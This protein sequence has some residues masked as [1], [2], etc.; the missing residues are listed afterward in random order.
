MLVLRE[1]LEPP[2]P[3]YKG[4]ASTPMLAK[5]QTFFSFHVARCL[6]VGGAGFEPAR[7]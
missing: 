7:A 3:L 4:G 2:S 1:G 6:M 5:L